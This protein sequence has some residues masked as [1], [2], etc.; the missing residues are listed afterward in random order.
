MPH[1]LTRP[2]A[3][4]SL[5]LTLLPATAP[6]AEDEGKGKLRVAADQPGAYIYVNGQKKA[7]VGDEGYTNI[8]LPE[9]EYEI[10]VEKESDD[11]EFVWRGVRKTFVGADTSL[12]VQVDLKKQASAKRLERLERLRPRIEALQAQVERDMVTVAAGGFRM[13]CI[14]NDKDCYDSEKPVRTVQVGA[15]AIGRYEVTF[16]QYDLFCEATGREKPNDQGWGRG[17]RPVINVSWLD[18]N[19]F[20]AWLSQ[21]SGRTYRLPTEAEWEVAARAGTETKFWWGDAVGSNRAN[22]D[23]CG[24]RWDNKQ[25]A[26]VGSFAANKWGLYDTAGNVWEW[27]CSAWASPYDGSEQRCM[28][29]GVAFRVERGGRWLNYPRSVRSAYRHDG[30]P[31]GRGY[32]LGFRLARSN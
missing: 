8:L 3:I 31:G 13:G 21:Q 9:G 1:R 5:L 4:L 25:T 26:P 11:G 29:T 32:A 14:E 16:D 7:M 20:A 15:F 6:L 23:G 19:A 10:R 22:C 18:A 30:A 24:S 12:K 27:T 17:N 28:T 2:V